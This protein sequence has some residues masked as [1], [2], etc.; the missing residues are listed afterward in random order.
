MVG[1]G[2][3]GDYPSTPFLLPE[4]YVFSHSHRKWISNEDKIGIGVCVKGRSV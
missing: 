4:G 3:V 1:M 2:G